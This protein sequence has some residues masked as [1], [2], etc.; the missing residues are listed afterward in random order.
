V[1]SQGA[2]RACERGV[3]HRFS[4]CRRLPDDHGGAQPTV[5]RATAT[6]CRRLDTELKRSTEA[7]YL[8]AGQVRII[9]S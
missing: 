2:Y 1:F 5:G 3:A 9:A 4:M 7:G 6:R 8:S